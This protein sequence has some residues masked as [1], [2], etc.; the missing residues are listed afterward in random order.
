[1]LLVVLL[2][3]L[4]NSVPLV[5]VREHIKSNDDFWSLDYWNAAIKTQK[6]DGSFTAQFV[7]ALIATVCELAAVCIAC[8]ALVVLKDKK[9]SFSCLTFIIPPFF[10]SFE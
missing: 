5:N 10:Y 7:F 4:C 1:M 9:E 2:P 6:A 3:L 8:L